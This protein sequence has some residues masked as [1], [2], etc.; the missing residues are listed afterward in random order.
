MWQGLREDEQQELFSSWACDPQAAAE[1]DQGVG[2]FMLLV[3]VIWTQLCLA[4]VGGED[5]GGKVT[6]FSP[7]ISS[8]HVRLIRVANLNF[9]VFLQEQVWRSTHLGSSV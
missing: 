3:V 6:I 4:V 9:L 5:R 2:L 1:K 7:S 8:A